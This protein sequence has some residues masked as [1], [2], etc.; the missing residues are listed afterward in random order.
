MVISPTIQ[1][2]RGERY[3]FRPHRRT[4]VRQLKGQKTRIL[5]RDVY[6]AAHGD[7]PVGWQVHHKDRNRLNN[8]LDNLVAMSPEDHA[9]EHREEQR[10]HG[11][12]IGVLNFDRG[13]RKPRP[14]ELFVCVE[15][16]SGY[17]ARRCHGLKANKYCSRA[18]NMRAYRRRKNNA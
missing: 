13:R 14:Q 2:F 3:W 15:C 8:E 9:A 1:E 6:S 16:G 7:V 10:A 4:F 11:L 5:S 17:S 12:R 18:C